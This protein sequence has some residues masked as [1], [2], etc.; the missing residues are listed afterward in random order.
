VEALSLANRI[1]TVW[2][3]SAVSDALFSA[4]GVGSAVAAPVVLSASL[5][6]GAAFSVLP[7]PP[8]GTSKPPTARHTAILFFKRFI[9]SS[10][11]GE[12]VLSRRLLDFHL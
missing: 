1:A 6:A 4:V 10:K 12:R 8:A 3:C 5:V 9:L 11:P 2:A 7:H